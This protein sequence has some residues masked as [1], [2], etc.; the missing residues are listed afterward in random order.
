MK[1]ELD[2]SS[3]VKVEEMWDDKTS[4]VYFEVSVLGMLVDRVEMDP[5]TGSWP[6]TASVRSAAEEQLE[7]AVKKLW[8]MGEEEEA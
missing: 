3:F 7:R 6:V 5:V 2:I 8:A 1:I 4:S